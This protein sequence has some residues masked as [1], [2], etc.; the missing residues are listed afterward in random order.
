MYIYSLLYSDST[1]R[2][3]RR[4]CYESEVYIYRLVIWEKTG[5]L[6]RIGPF[7]LRAHAHDE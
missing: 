7:M 1:L 4:H 2:A 3:H 5:R 6:V